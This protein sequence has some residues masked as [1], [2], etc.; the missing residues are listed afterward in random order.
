VMLLHRKS[1]FGH[2]ADKLYPVKILSV[3]TLKNQYHLIFRRSY[4]LFSRSCLQDGTLL[5]SFQKTVG[6]Q[7]RHFAKEVEILKRKNHK[8]SLRIKYSDRVIL[9]ILN[10]FGYIKE[11]LLIVKPE[12]VLK[13]QRKLIKRLG[14]FRRS[15]LGGRPP[16]S[17]TIEQLNI[18]MKND[19][20]KWGAR[21]I[22]GELLKLDIQLNE[23]TIRN[24]LNDY[25]R[26]GMIK[27][28]LSWK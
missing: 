20:L 8:K 17:N 14:T 23:K 3:N 13:W 25:R 9:S 27:K 22:Q 2:G 16:E 6:N 1:L 4:V 15:K 12:T 10:I 11:Q 18:E 5:S 26:K 24:I 7:Y 28:S 21:K 19:N